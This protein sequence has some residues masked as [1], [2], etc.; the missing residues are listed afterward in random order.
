MIPAQAHATDPGLEGELDAHGI[1]F[2]GVLEVEINYGAAPRR[3]SE[4]PSAA[5]AESSSDTYS[6]V[7]CISSQ[8]WPN[9]TAAAAGVRRPP[10]MEPE[11]SL[12]CRWTRVPLTIQMVAL[13]AGVRWR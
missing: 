12:Q 1:D 4:N 5:S 11:E 13:R 3:R 10:R 8:A 7:A 2:V 9:S 6:G